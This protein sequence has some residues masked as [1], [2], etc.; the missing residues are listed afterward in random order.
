MQ[1]KGE[2]KNMKKLKLNLDLS[3]KL[4]KDMEN[5]NEYA[6][7]GSC[8]NNTFKAISAI[9]FLRSYNLEDYRVAYGFIEKEI[10][11]GSMYFR[12]A[13]LINNTDESVVDV[14]ACLW[15]DVEECNAEYKYYTF[16]EYETLNVYTDAL[17]RE[18]GM[19]A[20]H[21][22]TKVEEVT[23]VNKL[24]QIGL[25]YNP[26]DLMDLITRVYG[27]NFI[28]GFREYEKSKMIVL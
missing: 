6:E 28:E 26:V 3:K 15:E 20:L 19:P 25:S 16:K 9:N 23:M 2:Y 12:H 1:N 14:T 24:T 22:D 7:I 27:R 4:L 11:C 10:G 5:M 17:L 8:Y 21:N 18:S 13:F